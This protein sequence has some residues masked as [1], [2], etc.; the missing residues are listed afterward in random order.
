MMEADIDFALARR[1]AVG[2]RMNVP[3]L[4]LWM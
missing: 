4:Q 3:T 2:S 1:W